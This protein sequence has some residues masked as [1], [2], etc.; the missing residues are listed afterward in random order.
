MS[1]RFSVVSFAQWKPGETPDVSFVPP[2]NRRRLS[3]LQRV[4]FA[5]GHAL[6]EAAAKL[7]VF[8]SSRD[9]EDTLTRRQVELF[10]ATGEVSPGKFSSSVYNAA[11]GLWSIFTGNVEPYTALAAGEETV[12]AGLLDALMYGGECVWIYA[13][14]TGGGYGCAAHFAPVGRGGAEIRTDFSG[15][16]ATGAPLDYSDAVGF[17]TGEKQIL[18]GRYLTLTRCG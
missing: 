14:E 2:L 12:E 8:F 16:G 11:P 9:G 1:D 4:T 3:L 6:G 7:P 15:L 5:L 13:E 10:N 17:F 18:K